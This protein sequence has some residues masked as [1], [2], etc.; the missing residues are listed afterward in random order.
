VRLTGA[1]V[2][3][4]HAQIE[5]RAD[6][7]YLRDLGSATGV[8]INGQRVAEQRLAGGDEIEL[9][10]VKL[11]FE[12]THELPTG[13]QAFDSLQSVAFAVVALL[14]VGQIALFVWIFLQPHPRR[15]RTDIVRGA[16]GQ[17]REARAASNSVPR[18]LPPLPATGPVP[19][20]APTTEVLNRML[21]ITRVDRADA[22]DGVTV[23][24]QIKAQV[25]ERQLQ[26]G[27]AS[28]GVQFFTPPGKP[29]EIVWLNMPAD[30]ENFSTRTFAVK[31]SEPPAECAGFVVRT[32]YRK[33]LQDVYA[34]PATLASAP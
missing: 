25:G 13:R 3:D 34:L 2:S 26:P 15:G 24:I 27:E 10:G 29:K 12:I 11:T 1:G 21:R 18:Q 23:R 14:V 31:L 32:Y 9:G 17:Q 22:A 4:R 19:A 5:Q 20:S 28:V 6:G 33:K 8:R 30:W 7:Y 16:R